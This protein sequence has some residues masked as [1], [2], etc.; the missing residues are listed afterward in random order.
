MRIK[1]SYS[2]EGGAADGGDRSEDLD[3]VQIE[4]IEWTFF[5]FLFLFK[6]KFLF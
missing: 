6:F 3:R 5:P 1:L 4:L 2:G